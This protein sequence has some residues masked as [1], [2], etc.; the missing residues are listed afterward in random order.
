MIGLHHNLTQ[1]T[2]ET[3]TSLMSHNNSI[4]MRVQEVLVSL[5]RQITELSAEWDEH[6]RKA[7]LIAQI[8]QQVLPQKNLHLDSALCLGLW[9]PERSTNLDSFGEEYESEHYE[10][11]HF[12]LSLFK[13]HQDWVNNYKPKVAKRN[14]SLFQLLIFETIMDCLRM[15]YPSPIPGRNSH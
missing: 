7:D 15:H 13:S 12:P 9:S 11:P 14:R 8:R 1:S 2:M 3:S 4:E 10:D 6:P 5:S